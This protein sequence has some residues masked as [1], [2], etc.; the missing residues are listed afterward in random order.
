MRTLYGL[1]VYRQWQVV[2]AHIQ[3]LA[4]GDAVDQVFYQD[5]TTPI[6][7]ACINSAPLELVDDHEGQARLEEEVPAGHHQQRWMNCP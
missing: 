3:P 4:Y 7:L 1:V 6:M 2:I 5:I